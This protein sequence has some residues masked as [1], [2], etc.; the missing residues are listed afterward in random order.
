MPHALSVDTYWDPGKC[1]ASGGKFTLESES[2]YTNGTLIQSQGSNFG[3]CSTSTGYQPVTCGNQVYGE[4][5]VQGIIG[6]TYNDTKTMK[7]NTPC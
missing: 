5:F 3:D 4:G 2:W 1:S 6:D 7:I